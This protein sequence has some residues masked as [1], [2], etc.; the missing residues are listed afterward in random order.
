[1]SVMSPVP[2][3]DPL[4]V[5]W[6]AYRQT[7]DYANTKQWAIQADHTEGSLW[8]AFM[9]GFQAATIRAAE[10][11]EQIDSAS[12]AERID[13]LPGAGAMGAIVEYRD[14]IRATIAA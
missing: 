4:M 9:A 7:D 13:N 5:A 10:L 12:D 11:H 6:E 14:R 2:K 3:A 8:A 1:M